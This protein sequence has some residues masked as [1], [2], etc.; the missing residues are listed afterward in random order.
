MTNIWK[1]NS[2][3]VK[4]SDMNTVHIKNALNKVVMTFTG[5]EKKMWIA[6]FNEELKKRSI[7]GQKEILKKRL[8]K[9]YKDKIL[10]VNNCIVQDMTDDLLT[11][12]YEF[13]E[14][15]SPEKH[16][17]EVL[18]KILTLEIDARIERKKVNKLESM[19]KDMWDRYE[20]GT[21]TFQLDNVKEIPYYRIME[22][23][24][25]RNKSILDQAWLDI[26]TKELS[27]RKKAKQ[28]LLMMA[29]GGLALIDE[30]KEDKTAT[31]SSFERQL[32]DF[33]NDYSSKDKVFDRYEKMVT[34]PENLFVLKKFEVIG[35][36]IA[37]SEY[38][39]IPT[40]IGEVVAIKVS[41]ANYAFY[42][43]SKIMKTKQP[44]VV[45]FSNG[46]VKARRFVK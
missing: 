8:L 24:E 7:E 23:M 40:K 41:E 5:N 38:I 43:V 35:S 32:N 4:V 45:D 29:Y 1:S 46:S 39:S 30:F 15:S 6:I 27:I 17:Q 34:D 14:L 13:N 28:T 9:S 33:I 21:L 42:K 11:Y 19:I 16:L 2:G 36:G 10:Y 26:F 25:L 20:K 31:I 12:A 37:N 3:D 18:R 44:M 22:I